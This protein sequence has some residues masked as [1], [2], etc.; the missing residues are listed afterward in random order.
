MPDKPPE[1]YKLL[2]VDSIFFLLV[3][4][5]PNF[6]LHV[7]VGAVIIVLVKSMVVLLGVEMDEGSFEVFVGLAFV[8]DNLLQDEKLLE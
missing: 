2:R 3:A 7:I 8:E 5:G 6:E 1:F 4:D